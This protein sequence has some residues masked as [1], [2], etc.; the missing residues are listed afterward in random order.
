MLIDYRFWIGIF[1]KKHEF[2]NEIWNFTPMAFKPK[3][4]FASY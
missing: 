4:R 1:S 3:P 2:K